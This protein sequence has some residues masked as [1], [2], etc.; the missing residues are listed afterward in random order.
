MSSEVLLVLVTGFAV[1]LPLIPLARIVRAVR[2]VVAAI[3][4]IEILVPT[5]ALIGHLQ[6]A[7]GTDP[8]AYAAQTAQLFADYIAYLAGW[9]MGVVLGTVLEELVENLGYRLGSALEDLMY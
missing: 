9:S 3:A 1:G 7:P 4:F 2:K 6:L 5:M 8:G